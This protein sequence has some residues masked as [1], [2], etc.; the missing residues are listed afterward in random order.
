MASIEKLWK[1][2][3]PFLKP[4]GKMLAMKGGDL[5][6]ELA[7]LKTDFHILELPNQYKQ[8]KLTELV[9]IEITPHQ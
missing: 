9:I 8:G 3:Q 4:D 6:K 7:R 2:S 1:W 5:T